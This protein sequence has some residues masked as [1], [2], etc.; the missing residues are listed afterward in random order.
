MG[1]RQQHRAHYSQRKLYCDIIV[2][3][4]A[5]PQYAY[6]DYREHPHIAI[7]VDSITP[8]QRKIAQGQ[9]DE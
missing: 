9:D 8:N 2:K 6:A 3:V 5:Q 1:A 7:P 4:N